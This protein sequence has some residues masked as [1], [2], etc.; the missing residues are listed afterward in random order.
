MAE[1]DFSKDPTPDELKTI[2]ENS[3]L[4]V[5]DARKAWMGQREG[6]RVQ[7]GLSGVS[8]KGPL[9]RF[10]RGMAQS[11]ESSVMQ[12]EASPEPMGGLQPEA[13][14][15]TISHL[16][17]MEPRT[18]A[19]GVA[20]TVT[21]FLPETT[22]E[23]AMD[24]LL[25]GR[26]FIPRAGRLG[27]RLGSGVATPLLAG[28]GQAAIDVGT[29][30]RTGGEAL[31]QGGVRALTQGVGD[32]LGAASTKGL[33][34]ADARS[35]AALFAPTFPNAGTAEDIAKIG[36]GLIKPQR[37]YTLP[38]GQQVSRSLD[39]LE[40]VVKN[41]L[42]RQPHVGP[43]YL[44]VPA[45]TGAPTIMVNRPAPG[46]PSG[47]TGQPGAGQVPFPVASVDDVIEQ[48]RIRRAQIRDALRTEEPLSREPLLKWRRDEKALEDALLRQ[49]SPE[50]KRA[51]EA[52][53]DLG[54]KS[55]ALRKMAQ[56]GGLFKEATSPT[57]DFQAL[58][59]ELVNFKGSETPLA[60]ALEDAFKNEPGKFEG[61]LKA[62]YRGQKEKL[63][64]QDVSYGPLRVFSMLAGT[65]A[66][67]GL[68]VGK[69]WSK[70][71]QI[72]RAVPS[73]MGSTTLELGRLGR[74]FMRESPSA[75][76]GS[77]E[78]Q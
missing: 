30:E 68:P 18:T 72:S 4:S 49:L 11:I 38:S 48:I 14:P 52:F 43:G 47:L 74:E 8:L 66:A 34:A 2:A 3:G 75:L 35:M 1:I 42:I 54:R 23:A 59:K 24:A 22:G 16:L 58:H 64:S 36:A 28:A 10:K 13:A 50:G 51:W 25:M 21:G 78:V 31:I 20:G 77:P 37:L 15:G 56:V 62:I 44:T 39:D 6:Q 7:K 76:I 17:G 45:G 60:K 70:V 26:G 5:E 46:V 19:R 27:A 12:H 71:G 33:N 65:G 32:V 53:D 9:G 63:G 69:V 73:A 57:I 67:G 61:I 29:G 40:L 55:Y 41:S